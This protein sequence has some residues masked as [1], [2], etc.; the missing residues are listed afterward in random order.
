MG[1]E[2]ASLMR[3]SSFSAF[4]LSPPPPPQMVR[5]SPSVKPSIPAPQ[6][7][8]TFCL[9]VLILFTFLSCAVHQTGMVEQDL[10]VS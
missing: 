1:G 10:S 3:G 7:T 9:L 5:L 4:F 6:I 8:L 2:A